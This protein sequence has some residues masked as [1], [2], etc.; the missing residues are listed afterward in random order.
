MKLYLISILTLALTLAGCTK[1]ASNVSDASRPVTSPRP[2]HTTIPVD[3]PQLKRITTTVVATESVPEV[4]I[5]APGK[6]EAN[7][8]QVSKIVMPVVGRVGR[9]LV[10]LGD[11]VHKGQPIL[12]VDSPDAASAMSAFRQAEANIAIARAGVAKADADLQRT[13]DLYEHRAA[14][15]K[16][17][18]A[19]ET[20]LIQAKAAQTES[21]ASREEALKRLEVLGLAQGSV[22]NQLVSV[23]TSISGKVI[24]ISAV[25]GEFRNDTSTP[26]ATV[27][28]LSTVWIAADVPED[29]VRFA[30]V[31]STVRIT[32]SA[33][34][35]ETFTGKVMRVGDMVDPQTRT[36]KVRAQLPNPEGRFRPEMFAQLRDDQGSVDLPVVPR[37]ALIENQGRTVIYVERAHGDFEEVAVVVAWQGPDRVAIRSGIHAGDR[38]VTTGGMLLRTN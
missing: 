7:P 20:V 15:Q 24:D 22:I 9:V 34:P 8:T 19:A 33:F 29:Q 2:G 14:A 35:G 16:E 36:V 12:T 28:D 17:V 27:A 25:P 6:V 32:L 4:E 31:G 23:R 21:E 38:V 37:T 13:K 18:M 1:S 5:V 11:T 30:K 10:N 3:S 26:I